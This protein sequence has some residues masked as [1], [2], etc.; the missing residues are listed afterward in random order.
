VRIDT[1]RDG[2]SARLALEGR[3]DREW[4]ERLSHA[5]EELLQDGVRTLSLDFKGVTYVSSAATVVLARCR[6]ELELLRGEVRLS[7]VNPAVR[8]MFGMAGWNPEAISAES[9]G[10]AGEL[11]RSSWHSRADL[12]ATGHFELSTADAHAALTCRLV[13][14]PSRLATERLRPDECEVVHLPDD[15]FALGIGAI[16]GSPRDCCSRLGEFVAVAGCLAYFPSDGARLA[17][18]LVAGGPPPRALLGSGLVCT[19][20]FSHLLRFNTRAEADAVPLSELAS[21]ALKAVGGS[22]AG[23]VIAGETAGILGTRLRRSPAEAALSFDVPAVKDW[24][25]FP[26]QP[27]YPRATALIAGVVARSPQEPVAAHLRRLGAGRRPWGHW[28]AAIFSYRPLPQRTVE[29]TTLARTLYANHQL[30]DVLHLL[31]DGRGDADP[32]ESALVRGVAWVAP[33]ARVE[34]EPG[35]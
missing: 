17:D 7:S 10:V 31:C 6:Q 24:L 13:G 5:L 16:G 29:L 22:I 27:I 23:V 19:G 12:A 28:H 4:A 21:V 26:P 25:T 20:G 14:N 18:Y 1:E 15:A 34:P 2:G 11:R 32:I 3:L 8:E 35:R 9:G 30:R 33:I